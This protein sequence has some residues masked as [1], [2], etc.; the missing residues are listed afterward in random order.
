M[1]VMRT[2]LAKVKT[3][4]PGEDDTGVPYNEYVIDLFCFR[5]GNS[6]GQLAG[7]VVK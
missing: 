3:F 5:P 7:L 6:M 4:N 1:V 2:Q